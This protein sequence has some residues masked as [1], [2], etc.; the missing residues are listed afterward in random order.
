[1]LPEK[2]LIYKQKN[3]FLSPQ[4]LKV[5]TGHAVW[6]YVIDFYFRVLISSSQIAKY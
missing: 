4:Y 6:L 3:A 1:M 2:Y 5:K